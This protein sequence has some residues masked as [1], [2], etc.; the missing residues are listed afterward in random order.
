VWDRP[1]D[2]DRWAATTRGRA[3]GLLVGLKH[4]NADVEEAQHLLAFRGSEVGQGA[5]GG[6]GELR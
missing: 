1:L 4:E 2:P 5:C 6:F 3:V